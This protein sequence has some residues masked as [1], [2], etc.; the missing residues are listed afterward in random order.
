MQTPPATVLRLDPHALTV[1]AHPLRSRLVAALRTDGPAT[2]TTLARALS[3]NSGATSYHLRKLASVSLVEETDDG[4]G[5]E[6]WWR[7]TTSSHGWNER[8]VEGHPD[9]QAA[10]DWLRR[11]YLDWFVENY[12]RWLDNQASWPLEWRDVGG[13]NDYGLRLS[14]ERL[15]AFV[16]EFERLVEAYRGHAGEPGEETLQVYLYAFPLAEKPS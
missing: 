12:A 15:T 1:L 14:P 4:H 9:G 16:S 6:R 2:A 7:A 8:D 11:H 13:A 5:R 10:S 3:T